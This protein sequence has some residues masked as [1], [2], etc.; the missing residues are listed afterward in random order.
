MP[1]VRVDQVIP[2]LARPDAIGAHTL[3]LDDALTAAGIESHIYY[4]RC[5]TPAIAHRGRPLE[6]LHRPQRDRWLLYQM[7]IGSPVFDLVAA[8]PEPV[9]V[10]YHNITPAALIERWEPSIGY[11]LDLGRTQLPRLADRCPLAIGVSSFN[12]RELQRAGYRHTAVVPLLVEMTA[13]GEPDERTLERLGNDKSR[14][15][16]DLLFVGKISP[17][18]APH[19][20][21][22]M[23]AVYRRL[24]DRRVRLHLIGTPISH[25]YG[26]AVLDFVSS[27]DLDVTVELRGALHTSELEAY[28]RMAD[29]YVSASE[30]EGFCAPVIESMAHGVPVVAYRAGAVPETVANAGLL[31]GNKD[32][33]RFA[34]AVA[35]VVHDPQLRAALTAA[36]ERRA[37]SFSLERSQARMVG[38][39]LSVV[40]GRQDPIGDDGG[41]V[42]ERMPGEPPSAGDGETAN[43][44]LVGRHTTGG[45]RYTRRSAVA[46]RHD[47]GDVVPARFPPAHARHAPLQSGPDSGV[48]NGI[49]P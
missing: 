47:R 35:R 30:H 20:L 46:D 4:G 14:G 29:A 7:S 23:A 37:A 48:G 11:E 12:A 26:D 8:R 27:L 6:H 17:H 33:V 13:P 5:S 21:I 28:Y 25:M 42:G 10:N 45:N 31:L 1:P 16:V 38:A 2:T 3:A 24:Y 32:P 19:D 15:G 39:I 34:A 36:G 44:R 18:K 22:K 41:V 9:I 40:E 43:Q 49:G